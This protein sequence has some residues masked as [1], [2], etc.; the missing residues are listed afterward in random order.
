MKITDEALEELVQILI[1]DDVLPLISLLVKKKNVSE[2]KLAE[3]LNITVNQTRNML[4]RLNEHNLV[5]FMRKKDKK[6]GWYIYYWSLNKPSIKNAMRKQKEKQLRTLTE[7]LDREHEGIF[8]VCPTGCMRLKIDA[9]MEVEF[10]CQECGTLMREQDNTKTIANIRRMVAELQEELEA[11][12]QEELERLERIRVRVERKARA[13]ERAKLA[14]KKKKVKKV[15]KVVKKKVS[16]KKVAKKPVKKKVKKTKAKKKVKKKGTKKKKVVKK[17]VS[18]KKVAKKKK[19]SKPKK[20]AR[21]SRK[22]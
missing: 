11:A 12:R 21:K 8:Y 9:A 1:G 16:K 5:S 7:R 2:F 14:K 15:K 10:R 13:E 22:K 17:K 3:M 19:V 18:K 20:K 4:Y 6:K